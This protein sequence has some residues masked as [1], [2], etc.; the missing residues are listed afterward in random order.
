[1]IS[2]AWLLLIIPGCFMG[3]VLLSM[4]VITGVLSNKKI[5][6]MRHE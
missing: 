5:T 3:G 4:V 2:V 1:M 6:V